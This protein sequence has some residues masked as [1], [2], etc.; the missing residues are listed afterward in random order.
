MG[1]MS[2][3]DWLIGFVKHALWAGSLY[4]LKLLLLFNFQN[5]SFIP[6]YPMAL[7]TGMLG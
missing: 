1:E 5:P 2:K 4:F 6:A 7:F 3:L